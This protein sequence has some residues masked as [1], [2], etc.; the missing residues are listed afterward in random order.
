[1]FEDKIIKIFQSEVIERTDVK[2]F[3][4][5]Q[6]KTELIIGCGKNAIKVLELMQEGKKRMGTEEFLRGFSFT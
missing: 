5:Q 2:R 4:I 6:S 3:K 1:L